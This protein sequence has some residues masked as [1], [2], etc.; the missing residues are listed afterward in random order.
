LANLD[1]FALRVGGTFTHIQPRVQPFIDSNLLSGWVT[2]VRAF[3]VIQLPTNRT[4]QPIQTALPSVET[5]VATETA[6]I[7]NKLSICKEISF[8]VVSEKGLLFMNG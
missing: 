6:P 3:T 7:S 5:D 2:Y 1:A 4:Q 8:T